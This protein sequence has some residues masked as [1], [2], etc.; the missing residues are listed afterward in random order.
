MEPRAAN[1]DQLNTSAS[2]IDGEGCLAASPMVPSGDESSLV[3]SFT[4]QNHFHDGINN[5]MQ[6][7][8]NLLYLLGRVGTADETVRE[9]VTSMQ[10]ELARLSLQLRLVGVRYRWKE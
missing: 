1:E 8:M 10:A 3:G 5:R 7:L 2:C 4:G 6:A 9:Y